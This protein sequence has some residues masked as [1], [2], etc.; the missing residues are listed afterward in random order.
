MEYKEVDGVHIHADIYVPHNRTPS[1]PIGQW[2]SVATELQ[3]TNVFLALMIHGGGHMTLSRKYIRP[4]QTRHLLAHGF[5]PVSLDFRLC[6]EVNL[7]DGP[8]TDVRDGYQWAK[9][10]LPSELLKRG[11]LVDSER[12][13][14]IGWSTGGHLALSLAWTTLEAGITP[15]TAI[16]SFYAPVNFDSADIYRDCGTTLSRP[17]V[18]VH[19]IIKTLPRKPITTYTP[20]KADENNHFWLQPGDVRSDL[21]ISIFKD[22][23]GLPLFLSGL[24][25]DTNSN[26]IEMPSEDRIAAIDPLAQ[27]RRDRYNTPT[28]IVHPTK[29]NIAPYSAAVR[30]ANELKS[31]GVRHKFL[32]PEGV[33][34]AFDVNLQQGTEEWERCV[35]P[36]YQFLFDSV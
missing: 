29:D 7:V 28:C 26:E 3:M 12:I 4:A 9:D 27:L 35:A 21:L 36:G 20:T 30:F 33:G 14:A 34:H 10:K 31:R 22:G 16:L 25:H 13:V 32:S 23:M 5:L 17:S 8:M 2:R 1:M 19:Q 24:P 11:V 15:P 6:P 18:S